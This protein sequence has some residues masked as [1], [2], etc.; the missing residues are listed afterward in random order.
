MVPSEIS[1]VECKAVRKRLKL[2]QQE[3]ADKLGVSR[4][5]IV[6]GERGTPSVLLN[7]A[8]HGLMRE[9]EN[10]NLKLQLKA[11]TE[12][13]EVT[14]RALKGGEQ[15]LAEEVQRLRKENADL[16]TA[17]RVMMTVRKQKP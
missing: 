3:F 12:Q 14:A 16:R 7:Q 17:I 13:S 8:V 2:T 1:G 9:Q 11:M 6:K 4:F 15:E 5:L 10:E